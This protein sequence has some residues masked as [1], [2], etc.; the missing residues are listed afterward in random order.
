MS[1]IA[2]LVI[3]A[4]GRSVSNRG[5]LYFNGASEEYRTFR[6]KCRLF[7]KTYHK[8]TPPKALVKMF[9]EWNLA[10][11]VACCIKG[12]E[13][14]PTAWTMLD[15]VYGS[16]LALTMDQTP[17]AGW[18]PELQEEESGVESEAGMSEEEPAPPQAR[19]AAVFRIVDAEVAR[20]AAKATNGPQEKHIFI[21]MSHGI[22]RLRCLWTRG[23]EPEHTVVSQEAAQRYGLKAESRRQGT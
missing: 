5:W 2:S 3:R 7:Q 19:G 4:S 17:E 20:P 16:P 13:D 21:Y 12:A 9:R 15:A 8:A 1:A 22:R 14:M 18:M 10:E 23:E 6:T 11:E